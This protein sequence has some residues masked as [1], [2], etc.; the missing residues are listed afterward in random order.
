MELANLILQAGPPVI[1]DATFLKKT[2]RDHFQ[3]LAQSL[4]V[5]Y[6]ILDL[7]ASEDTL[8]SRI[9]K[10]AEKGKDASEATLEVLQH[11]IT[12]NEAITASEVQYTIQV[13]MEKKLDSAAV[14]L[15][16][17]EIS[18]LIETE[19]G[20]YILK[21]TDNKVAASDLN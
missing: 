15:K 12:T 19:R 2:Q 10:R 14:K 11:Q 20:Y 4:N 13:D 5:P 3:Q 6:V 9:M 21:K 16:V 1:V 18:G 17:G 7:Q 8:R